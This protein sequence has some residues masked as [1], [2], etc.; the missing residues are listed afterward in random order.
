MLQLFNDGGWA[1]YPLAFLL[2]FGVAWFGVLGASFVRNVSS[3]SSGQPPDFVYVLF[4]VITVLFLGFPLVHLAHLQQRIG[5]QR[6]DV[7]YDYLSVVS[8]AGLDWIILGGLI[9]W[10]Q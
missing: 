9:G 5:W 2:I 4:G 8:K 6:A 1:M 3:S 7:Y 10:Q